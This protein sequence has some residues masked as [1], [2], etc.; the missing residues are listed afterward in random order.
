MAKTDDPSERDEELAA[1][2][3]ALTAESAE[4]A[5]RDREIAELRAA[6]Q[7]LEHRVITAHRTLAYGLGKA[8]I[9]ARSL[10]GLLALP[11]RLRRLRLRQHVKRAARVP[12]GGP[13]GAAALMRHVEPALDRMRADGAEAAAAW[14]QALPARDGE[15]KARALSE[16]AIAICE[17]EPALAGR[18]GR[19]AAA[20][21]PGSPRLLTLARLLHEQGELVAP[22]ALGEAFRAA[23]PL[24]EAQ[25]DYIE[26][27]VEEGRLL[28]EGHPDGQL[29]DV[30]LAPDRAEHVAI[31]HLPAER[32]HWR[33]EQARAVAEAAGLQARVIDAADFAIEHGRPPPRF[34]HLIVEDPR[35]ARKALTTARLAG[36]PVLLDIG[37]LPAWAS[38]S[39]ASERGRAER[40]R[41]GWLFGSANAVVA[42]SDFLADAIAGIGGA[43]PEIA[44][45]DF[46]IPPSVLSADAIETA[47]L[48]FGIARGAP[49]LGCFASLDG[50]AGC[51]RL[52]D[53]FAAAILDDAAEL[54]FF[55]RGPGSAALLRQAA[56]LGIGERVRF[57]EPPPA[58]RWPALMRSLDLAVFPRET[59][60]PAE[61]GLS[62][63]LGVARASQA[64]IAASAAAWRWRDGGDGDAARLLDD[65]DWAG[66][67]KTLLAGKRSAAPREADAPLAPIY[68]RLAALV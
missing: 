46:I 15:A 37:A 16:L 8:L 19:Q 49:S 39:P 25:G 40:V 20:I 21:D 48:E 67:L 64:R 45:D 68:R 13:V 17:T 36:S 11:R 35:A 12:D 54:H 7:H 27:L 29:R 33:V 22:A 58:T 62:A 50:D 55:G 51:A 65:Q 30:S 61:S 66:S 44:P 59:P 42:A 4:R 57:S 53:A 3:A 2:R 56:R 31:V 63:A 52:I 10:K 18:L 1:L 26:A 23:R 9:E 28:A 41:L 38:S 5:A 6:N 47:A 14:T 24:N 34:A 32:N 43:R 60:E